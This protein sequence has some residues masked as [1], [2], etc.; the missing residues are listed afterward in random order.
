MVGLM[1]GMFLAM[2]DN[3][4][5]GTALPTI[6]GD[7][8]GIAHLSWVVT[9]YALATA[10]AT[11]I[12][13]KLGDLYGRK[14]MFMAAIVIFLI[15]SALAGLSQ[16]M[17]QLIGF[18]ALQ[19]LGAGGLMVGAMAIIGDLVPPRERGRFQAMIGG[20]MPLAFVGGPLLGGFLTDNLSWRWAFYVN[21]PLGVLALLVTGLGMRLHTRHVKAKIDYIG[22][23]LLTVGI[24]A[25][26]LVAS[27]GGT[28][29]AWASTQII[30]LAVVSVLALAG[31]VYA[32]GRVPEPIL[33]PR[34][35]RDR[36]FTMAQILSFLVGA[37]MFGAV[38]FLPQYMQYVQGASATTSGLLLLPLMFGMLAVMLTTGQLIT[39]NGR[40]RIYPIIGGAVLTAGMLVLVLLKV[41][42]STFTSS[43]LTVVAGLGMGFIMQNTMLVTQN[44]VELRDMGAASGSVTLFRTIG[45]SLGVA[46][47]GSIYTS[48]LK[49]SLVDHLGPKAGHAM[50]SG[51]GVHVTPAALHTLPAPVRDAFKLGVTNGLHGTVLGGAVLALAGFVVAWF[52][53]EVPLRGSA[54]KTAPAGP[55]TS[56]TSPASAAAG[57]RHASRSE[58]GSETG[59][60][61][62]VTAP[63]PVYA[64]VDEY[65]PR[66]GGLIRGSVR[67]ADGVPAGNAALTLIDVDGHQVG[68]TTTRD[69]GRYGLVTPDRGTYVLV[70]AAGEHAPR[71]ATLVV[72]DQPVDLDLVLDGSGGLVGAVRDLEGTPV[73]EARVVVANVQ[74]EVVATGMT[75]A[76]GA[77]AFPEVVPGTYTVAVSAAGHRPA[78]VP[79]EVGEDRTR[80]DVAL[81]PGARIRGVVRAEGRGPLRDARVTLVD[82]AGDVV[83]VATTGPDGEYVFTDLTGGPYTVTASGYPPAA[84]TVVLNGHDEEAFDMWLGHP[85]G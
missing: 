27:W 40:Y 56:A 26:T 70:A 3:L 61:V 28:E 7:L 71:A 76:D 42:T 41:D 38:S 4:I 46:L 39:R 18:R 84:S 51:G 29:Y 79:V 24:V 36:N 33:P 47:L 20:M 78:A 81:P 73:P 69:D 16:N 49:D 23:T 35:F 30:V 67:G 43:A 9:A 34:L 10:A 48:R 83:R 22:A 74:G 82:A 50:T 53:R 2:L 65:D 62:P 15:G 58:P 19:G 80:Q 12:W 13:G 63:Q 5:V 14:G 37:A 68:R 72:G 57:G 45:G 54:P 60:S 85:A 66:G 8:G 64:P 6:V 52:I 1:L 17:D 25:L 32:E 21:L 44:S 59:T 75:G 11:P 77:Y 31:F 55:A